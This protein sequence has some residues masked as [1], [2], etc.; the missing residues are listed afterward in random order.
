MQALIEFLTKNILA[1]WPI[2]RVNTWECGLVVR[3]GN[4]QR[5]IGPGLHWRWW[6]I[7]EVKKWPSNE[8]ALDL[9]TAAITTTD[10]KS[11]AI[12]ANLS[13]RVTSIDALWREVWNVETS[14]GKVALGEI[15]TFCATKD[16]CGLQSER[17]KL[18]R[19]LEKQ[20]N[21]RVARWGLLIVRVCLTD[22]VLARPHRHYLDTPLK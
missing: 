8:I 17:E 10:G 4:I 20:L 1:L 9:A 12:S 16:W 19:S 13:Y 5:E 11:V 14:L 15:A 3:G 2:A 6:F 21:N 7:D 22:L 18:E